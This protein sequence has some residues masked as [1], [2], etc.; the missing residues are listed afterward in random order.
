LKQLAAEL[1]LTNVVFEGFKENIGDYFALFDIFVY[2]SKEEGLGSAILEAFHF[3]KPV[4]A[5]NI[6]GIPDILG[7]NEYGLLID[8]FDENQLAE[9]ILTLYRNTELR[10]HYAMQSAVRKTCFSADEICD[11][12]FQIY[13]NT[14][15]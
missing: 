4:I 9:T 11:C 2:P 7:D 13:Q 15:K 3:N 1:N 14:K 5:A 10:N 6:G 12:Y 8:P